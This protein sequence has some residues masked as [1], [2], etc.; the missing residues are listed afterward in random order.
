MIQRMMRRTSMMANI[1][2][3]ELFAEVDPAVIAAPA[4][5]GA[6]VGPLVKTRQGTVLPVFGQNAPWALQN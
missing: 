4:A 5:N 6:A 1:V 3:D 2:F